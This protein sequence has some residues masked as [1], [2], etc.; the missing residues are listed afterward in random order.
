MK[1]EI[2]RK[3]GISILSLPKPSNKKPKIF[4]ETEHAKKENIVF[5]QGFSIIKSKMFLLVLLI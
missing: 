2:R 3:Y 5:S 1:V 4:S